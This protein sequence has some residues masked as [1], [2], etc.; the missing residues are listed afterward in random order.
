LAIFRATSRRSYFRAGTE[1][2]EQDFGAR[3][4][5]DQEATP[6]GHEP[7]RNVFS[8]IIIGAA[9]RPEVDPLVGLVGRKICASVIV[10]V[11]ILAVGTSDYEQKTCKQYVL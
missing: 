1:T 8:I 11:D 5:S 7:E 10:V 3:W 2:H 9:S 4:Q 6:T